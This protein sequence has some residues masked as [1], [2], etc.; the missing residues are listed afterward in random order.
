METKVTNEGILKETTANFMRRFFHPFLK[1][2]GRAYGPTCLCALVV[3]VSCAATALAQDSGN[4]VVAGSI[5]AA[6][7]I[8][9]GSADVGSESAATETVAFAGPGD[10]V[11]HLQ[12]RLRSNQAYALSAQ[13][14]DFAT[15]NG[16]NGLTP[17][18]IVFAIGSVEVSGPNVAN[19]QDHLS[20]FLFTS[21]ARSASASRASH[22]RTLQEFLLNQVI[23]SGPRISQRGNLATNNNFLL[24]T[25]NTLH[26]DTSFSASIT[27]TLSAP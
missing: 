11:S 16:N 26:S 14:T 8:T 18:Q 2:F 20:Q 17:E 9:F 5:P 3:A 23:L 10:G 15:Y 1:G 7:S 24:V 25:L 6:F 21:G 27:L 4:A 13:L 19:P 22:P 12:I